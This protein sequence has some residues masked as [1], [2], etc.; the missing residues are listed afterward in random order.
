M[1]NE[2]QVIKD[3]WVFFFFFFKVDKQGHD[4]FSK[5]KKPKPNFSILFEIFFFPPFRR[6]KKGNELLLRRK[7]VRGLYGREV[8]LPERELYQVISNESADR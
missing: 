4:H 1:L 5:K 3:L 2:L 8:I 6:N 7:S